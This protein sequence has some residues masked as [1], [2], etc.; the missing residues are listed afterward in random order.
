M[1]THRH[2]AITI[3]LFLAPAFTVKPASAQQLPAAIDPPGMTKIATF[4]NL[5]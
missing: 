3:A 1:H 4:L 2:L 5:M